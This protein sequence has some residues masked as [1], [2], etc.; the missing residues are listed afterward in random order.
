MD[1]E[2]RPGFMNSPHS[3]SVL[4]QVWLPHRYRY[5]SKHLVLENKS[6]NTLKHPEKNQEHTDVLYPGKFDG[7][8]EAGAVGGTGGAQLRQSP[9]SNVAKS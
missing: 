2:T 7:F 6:L 3:P 4:R 1:K 8:P 5:R 9:T